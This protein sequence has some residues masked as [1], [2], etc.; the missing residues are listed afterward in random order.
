MVRVSSLRVVVGYV[1]SPLLGT[2]GDIDF[3][4]C[5]VFYLLG[6]SG[7][8]QAPYLQN[9]KIPY[10]KLCA[11]FSSLRLVWSPGIFQAAGAAGHALDLS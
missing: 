4:V 7:N 1:P 9:W 6:Q 10:V 3:S 11:S 8:F 2:Q 5:A